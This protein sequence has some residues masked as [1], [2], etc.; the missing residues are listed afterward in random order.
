MCLS[1]CCCGSRCRGRVLCLLRRRLS[2]LT[3]CLLTLLRLLGLLLVVLDL[4]LQNEL[5]LVELAKVMLLLCK[6]RGNA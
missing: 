4:L 3:L 6:D 2:R 5:L 1:C